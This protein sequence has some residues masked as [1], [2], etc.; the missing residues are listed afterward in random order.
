MERSNRSL[1]ESGMLCRVWTLCT[2]VIEFEGFGMGFTFETS[3]CG[4]WRLEV[5]GSVVSGSRVLDMSLAL[6]HIQAILNGV[7][8]WQMSGIDV[9]EKIRETHT[10]LQVSGPFPNVFF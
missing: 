2:S 10:Q 6:Q 8:I 5:G 3:L 4:G 7:F 1:T 9:T